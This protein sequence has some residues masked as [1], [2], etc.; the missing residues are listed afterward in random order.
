MKEEDQVILTIQEYEDITRSYMIV[1][2]LFLK[3]MSDGL[4]TEE[5]NN[6]LRY[7]R[8]ILQQAAD[9]FKKRNIDK[10]G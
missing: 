10:L 3:Y 6:K 2:E 7:A 8:V 9:N 4:M 5:D 1:T